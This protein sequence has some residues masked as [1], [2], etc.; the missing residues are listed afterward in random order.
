MCDDLTLYSRSKLLIIDDNSANLNWLEQLLEWAGYKNVRSCQDPLLAENTIREYEPDLIILDLHMPQISGLKIL[1]ELRQRQVA[2]EF[3]PVL[4][5]TGDATTKTR[6]EALEC[7]ASDFLT[8]PGEANEIILRV[9]NFLLT[10][11]MHRQLQDDNL[12]LETQVAARTKELADARME[13]LQCLASVAEYHDD[14]TGRHTQRVGEISGIVAQT[15]EMSIGQCAVIKLA[16]PLHDIGKIGISETILLK[17]GPLTDE[18][19]QQMQRHT[20]IGGQILD[21]RHSPVL[22]MGRQIALHHHERW[23]GKGYPFGLAGEDIPIS[24]RIVAIADVFDALIHNRPYKEAWT[25]SN[26]LEEIGSQSGTQFD[27]AVVDAFL[28]S[29]EA[30]FAKAA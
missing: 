3:L 7:G 20:V 25:V 5:F 26:A 15:L 1:T 23:D 28:R 6:R 18:E 4:V 30:I 16:A 29:R 19:R 17:P 12:R 22:Q 27:P 8:K 11:W 24:A 13:A 9:K 21:N 14:A 10:R 2:N